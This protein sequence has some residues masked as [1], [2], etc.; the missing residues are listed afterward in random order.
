MSS[1]LLWNFDVSSFMIL[2]GEQEELN[3]RLMHRPLSGCFTALPVGGLQTYLRSN[4]QLTTVTG[5]G[6]ITPVSQK[7]A[8]LRN[9]RLVHMIHKQRLLRDG[10]SST[11]RIPPGSRGVAQRSTG[12]LD[13][14][15]VV[16]SWGI[17]SA[18]IISLALTHSSWIGFVSCSVLVVVSMVLRLSDALTFQISSVQNTFP[19]NH[20]AT[21]ILGQRNSSLVLE[22]NRDDICHWTALGLE[23]RLRRSETAWYTFTKA[24][25]LSTLLLI[26]IIVPNGTLVDQIAFIVLNCFGQAS[27]K[28]GQ[29]LSTRSC[30]ASFEKVD[31]EQSATRTHVYAYLLGRFGNGPWVDKAGFLPGSRDWQLWRS[32][33]TEVSTDAKIL[34][35]ACFEEVS[36]TSPDIEDGIPHLSK[37]LP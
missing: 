1:D 20:E 29:C 23:T 27:T 31:I 30:L 5:L 35:K 15:W 18:I 10:L 4:E 19:D 24:L 22:G 6:Y 11:Y 33:V 17:F 26:F 14:V 9:M 37:T 21:V 36:E 3:L 32:R 16:L 25:A 13:L 8:P 28:I 7:T 12:H 2:L 34:Y